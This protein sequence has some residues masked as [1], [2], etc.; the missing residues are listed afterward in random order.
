MY[1]NHSAPKIG[2]FYDGNFLLHA[3]NYYNYI[4]PQR[5]RLSVNGLH[6][7]ICQRVAEEEGIDPKRCRVCEA[8]YFRGRLNAADAAQRGSQL[9][10]DRVFDDIL[11]SE[12]VHTHYLPLR[13]IYGRKEERGTDVWL[14]L[15]VFEMALL[16]KIDVAVLVV[17]DT[18][19]VPLVRKLIAMGVRVMLI[20][21]EFE[22]TN[23]DGTRIVTK[24]SHE[25]LSLAHYPVPMQEVIDCGLKQ[26]NQL[27]LNLFVQ[28]SDSR[29]GMENEDRREDEDYTRSRSDEAA[30]E[31][32]PGARYTSQILS[33]KNGYG[34]IK[35]PNNNLFFHSLDVIDG[36]FGELSPGD[37]VEFS[38][39]KNDQGQDVAKQVKRLEADDAAPK[40]DDSFWNNL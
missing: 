2:V 15:E 17:A 3:S 29:Q 21:W 8:H 30:A 37:E 38:I 35:Y 19:Y 28:T 36:E 40:S 5:R 39:D 4:H 12:G 11:M 9:Y 27:I 14:S 26:N 13:N 20:S 24:T 23:D 18:D 16:G 6:D 32:T 10:H 22:Y 34:F 31:R 25:L 33:L 1:S 7:F